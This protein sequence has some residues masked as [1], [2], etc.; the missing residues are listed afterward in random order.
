MIESKVNIDKIK[1][2]TNFLKNIDNRFLPISICIR[3][4]TKLILTAIHLR[5]EY[6]NK[7]IFTS[8]LKDCMEKFETIKIPVPSEEVKE[9]AFPLGF[10]RIIEFGFNILIWKNR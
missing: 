8:F 2:G 10:V 7:G 3:K 5:E 4:G 1:E 9:I 6:Q